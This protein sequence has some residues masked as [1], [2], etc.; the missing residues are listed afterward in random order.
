MI[1]EEL[2]KILYNELYP[3]KQTFV[4]YEQLSHNSAFHFSPKIF[5]NCINKIDYLVEIVK[6]LIQNA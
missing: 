1:K 5:K 3:I 4:S 2:K 6:K